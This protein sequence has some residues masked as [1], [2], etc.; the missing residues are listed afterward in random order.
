M[1]YPRRSYEA[2]RTK[3]LL[4]HA[5]S[6]R[7]RHALLDETPEEVLVLMLQ[8]YTQWQHMSPCATTYKQ[9]VQDALDRRRA[10]EAG[11]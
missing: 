11:Q 3:L 9:H 4:E 6:E 10:M 5:G 2:S 8:R 7:E 1:D